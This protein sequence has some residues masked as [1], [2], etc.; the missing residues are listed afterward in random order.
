MYMCT[1]VLYIFIYC[2]HW[3]FRSIFPPI[4]WSPWMTFG[5]GMVRQKIDVQ[6]PVALQKVGALQRGR[7][8]NLNHKILVGHG[9]LSIITIYETTDI[10]RHGKTPFM[11]HLTLTTLTHEFFLRWPISGIFRWP[12]HGPTSW[13]NNGGF[14]SH[15]AT[16]VHHPFLDWDFPWNK[17]S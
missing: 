6:V 16:P 12:S 10:V 5:S 9:D 15:R 3:G 2:E 7:W 11:K 17:P 1:C 8:K 4:H 14:L 13:I